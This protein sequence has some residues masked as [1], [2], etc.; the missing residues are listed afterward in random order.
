MAQKTNIEWTDMS[1]NPFRARDQHGHTGHYCE[2]ISQGCANCYASTMQKRFQMPEY[3]IN[4]GIDGSVYLDEKQLQKVL[5]RKKPTKF[6]WCDMTD[7]FLYLYPDEWIDKCFAVMAL[8]PQH[9]HQILTKRPERMREYLRDPDTRRRIVREAKPYYLM[10]LKKGEDAFEDGFESDMSWQLSHQD[11]Y[12]VNLPD[13]V[14]LGVSVEDQKTADERIPILLDTPAAVRWIS[15]EPLLGAID[16]A[17][18][19]YQLLTGDKWNHDVSGFPSTAYNTPSSKLDWVVVGG[20]SGAHARP[21]NIAWAESIVRQCKEAGVPV[22]MKQLGMKPYE[23]LPVL[24]IKTEMTLL[25]S[26]RKGGLIS[27]FPKSLQV[28]E[29]PV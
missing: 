26:N 29:Y 13:N 24:G 1:V 20:E 17:K 3:Q 5:R 19:G 4:T 23:M 22:F 9:T 6:F 8:T 10:T 27:E 15:A 16:L 25:L 21:M 11:G 2:K 28:R 18:D 12:W 7:M 14:W